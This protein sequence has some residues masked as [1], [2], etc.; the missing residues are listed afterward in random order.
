[1]GSAGRPNRAMEP[2][3]VALPDNDAAV[4]HLDQQRVVL[5]LGEHRGEL[6]QRE[7]HPGATA[8]LGGDS[9]GAGAGFV[10]EEYPDRLAIGPCQHHQRHLAG[11]DGLEPGQ[12]G[13]HLGALA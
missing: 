7:R 13:N 12:C 2:E 8:G 5:E 9:I 1:M 10:R 3:L 11:R 6:R 4:G